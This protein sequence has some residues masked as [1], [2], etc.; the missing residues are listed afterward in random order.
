M[1]LL[2]QLTNLGKLEIIE[3]YE[4]YDTPSLFACQNLSGQLFLTVWAEQTTEFGTWLYVPISQ[5]RLK[6]VRSGN[7]E[8]RDAFVNAED[9][10]V[11]KVLI[12]CDGSPDKV[13]I[14]WC[15]N[16]IDDWL[17]MSYEFLDF[18]D[19]PLPIWEIKDAPRTAMQIQR[20]VLN[21]AFQFRT[22]NPTEAPVAFLGGILESV[23][24][25]FN[26]LGQ[27]IDGTPTPTGMIPRSITEKTQLTVLGT[28]PG[29]F[30]IELATL[31][32]KIEKDNANSLVEIALNEFWE[33]VKMSGDPENNA[34]ILRQKLWRL[35]SRVA[36]AYRDFLMN[37]YKSETNLR[38]NW[39]SPNLERGGSVELPLSSIKKALE[40][41]NRTEDET[42]REY[43]I[44]GKLIGLHIR[45]KSYEIL[46]SETN[47]KYSGRII[48]E[49]IPSVKTATLSIVYISTI[50]EVKE[51]SPTIP[52]GKLK[53][54]LLALRPY[55]S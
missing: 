2:P 4:Y 37:L 47:K 30:G 49:A 28:Y 54:K 41:I 1:S 11:Y 46:N 21:L 40:V 19:V 32:K 51:I 8:L 52:E 26:A 29:S 36:S 34:D 6:N 3:V 50:R 25:F 16:L 9:G 15:E 33:L 42:V 39:G 53:Y 24:S 17:P 35:K 5:R 20:E 43:E 7:I 48:D 38:F 31:P 55:R 44:V 12:S 22:T 13:E 14:I 45:N 10:F 18:G 23:Q 27:A